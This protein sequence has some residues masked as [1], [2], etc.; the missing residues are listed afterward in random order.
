MPE[1]NDKRP[2]IRP[3]CK[4]TQSYRL[5]AAPPGWHTYTTSEERQNAWVCDE[6]E[7]HFD[8]R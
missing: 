1:E 4:G 3:G 2:C 7:L 6:D 5:G 8:R